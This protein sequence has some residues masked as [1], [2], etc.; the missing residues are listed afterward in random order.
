MEAGIW[1]NGTNDEFQADSVETLPSQRYLVTE[2]DI[3]W[4]EK[5]RGKRKES[6]NKVFFV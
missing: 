1:M 5:K 4:G 3:R 2:M 6:V